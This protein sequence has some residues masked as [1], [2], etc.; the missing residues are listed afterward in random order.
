MPMVSLGSPQYDAHVLRIRI[1]TCLEALAVDVV[2][3]WTQSIGETCGVDEQLALLVA[4]AK[5]A[6]VDVDVV[7]ST[8]FESEVHH[9]IGLRFQ[10]RVVDLIAIGV[11]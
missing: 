1:D 2:Y 4:T 3:Q 8:L 5:E 9:R 7:V 10:H 6:I 11:P